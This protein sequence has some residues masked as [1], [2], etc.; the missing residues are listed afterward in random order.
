MQQGLLL[1]VVPLLF[2]CALVGVLAYLIH[3]VAVQ[4][5]REALVTNFERVLQQIPENL[6]RAG[7]YLVSGIF[8]KSD[9]LLDSFEKVKASLPNQIDQLKQ[10]LQDEPQ[11]KQTVD[12]KVVE[13]IE[14][15]V[16]SAIDL[17]QQAGSQQELKQHP[18]QPAIPLIGLI[19]LGQIGER[20]SNQ[21]YTVVQQ[22]T[23]SIQTSPQ[24]QANY[25][26]LVWMAICAGAV[27]NTLIAIILAHQFSKGAA[28]RI[29]LLLDNMDKLRAGEVINPPL[30][31]RD[32]IAQLDKALRDMAQSL[33]IAAQR[34]RASNATV[35]RMIE[36][37]P[38]ALLVTTGSGSIELA[39]PCALQMLR[40]TA[41][42]LQGKDLCDVLPVA[43]ETSGSFLKQLNENPDRLIQRDTVRQ[44][45]EQLSINVLATKIV[46]NQGPRLLLIL[47]DVTERSKVEKLR[48]QFVSMISHDLRAPLTSVLGSLNLLSA[49]AL[50]TIGDTAQ[51]C[52]TD[53]EVAIDKLI[54]LVRDLLDLAKTDAR[55]MPLHLSAIKLDPLIHRSIGAV[56]RLAEAHSVK[57]EYAGTQVQV[58]ADSDRLVQ[59]F[60]N[61]LSNAVRFS[62]EHSPVIVSVEE[63]SD[64][65]IVRFLDYGPGVMNQQQGTT[66]ERVS[67]LE[68]AY[69]PDNASTA[70]GL[71]IC[72]SIIEQHGGSIG[73]ESETGKGNA[74][75]VRIPS[76][77]EQPDRVQD[78][79]HQF[80]EPPIKPTENAKTGRQK[81]NLSLLQK[82]LVLVSIPLIFELA[83]VAWLSYLLHQSEL[84]LQKLD[85]AR[86]YRRTTMA[87]IA[88]SFD[89]GRS[90]AMYNML[91]SARALQRYRRDA[92]Q[93]RIY[94]SRLTQL[95]EQGQFNQEVTAKFQHRVADGIRYMD[96]TANHARLR[97][98]HPDGSSLSS[99]RASLEGVLSTADHFDVSEQSMVETAAAQIDR[100]IW[101]VLGCG[102]AVNFLLA[103][104]LAIYFSRG[105]ASRLL[106]VVTN[107]HRLARGE[108]LNPLLTGSD[109]VAQ[110][111][112][113]F[114]LMAYDLKLAAE[115]ERLINERIRLTVE[116][117]PAGLFVI[118][119]DGRI[120]ASNSAAL[121]MFT[122]ADETHLNK[123]L[124]QIVRS[125]DHETSPD[126]LDIVSNLQE[127]Q[128]VQLEV[129][130]DK[131]KRFTA[132]LSAVR[133]DAYE[134]PRLMIVIAD[135]TERRELERL[136]RELIDTVY[137]DLSAPL[138][139]VHGALDLL[140]SG[141]LG[142]LPAE[143]QSTA[144]VASAEIERL[145]RLVEELL[146]WAKSEAGNITLHVA[147]IR[148]DS[149]LQQALAALKYSAENKRISIDS[150]TTDVKLTADS[151]RLVQVLVN[152]LSNAIKFSPDGATINIVVEKPDNSIEVQVS[153][154]GRGVPASQKEAIF[155]EFHQVESAD[156]T[157]RGGT[158][159]GLPICK[160][161]ITAHGGTIGVRDNEGGGSIFWFRLPCDRNNAQPT[162]R[163]Q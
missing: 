136:K 25:R 61:L 57:I 141:A 113:F 70:L 146:N 145:R 131:A 46:T 138:S 26:R 100:S 116:N 92:A 135:V 93:M 79:S 8:F 129:S 87:L 149:V 97:N 22:A 130:G 103:V 72:K 83:L 132:E 9:A 118:D 69:Q 66:F 55:K 163:D 76:K 11:V 101:L 63:A 14:H 123:H 105:T 137:N 153:D 4:R 89:G 41:S 15:E 52:V 37:I 62:A 16:Y 71:S 162:S 36:T 3:Q 159:L 95:S 152:L 64:A 20:I 74:F 91:G 125:V 86:S 18:D 96:E 157:I 27:I 155:E 67:Q 115:K 39:N 19:K 139:S 85:A 65:I 158:G 56:R 17:M 58:T 82:G 107:T 21:T 35:V 7:D 122:A 59:V 154:R 147:R 111:D 90:V 102:L 5:Q 77:N 161:I 112:R 50:G 148:F 12:T 94:S 51:R 10:V 45:H 142:K 124:N 128:L 32:E 160:R 13:A 143:A 140:C 44:N 6:G 134:E 75:W 104:M 78:L 48:Q 43:N 30:E 33:E 88:L 106:A 80:T 23:S 34:E 98:Q 49:G 127:G 120:K 68:P 151:D 29:G 1:V 126:M 109:E 84:S 42:Q 117:M 108:P 47:H 81:S 38:V 60:I 40:C 133:I 119:Q 31:G 24:L 144:T 73:V 156:A 121:R 54:G 99:L 114:H 53:A 110:L 150:A 2:E 28:R